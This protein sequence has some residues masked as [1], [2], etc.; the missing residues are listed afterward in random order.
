MDNRTN[1]ERTM[2]AGRLMAVIVRLGDIGRA[3]VVM[4]TMLALLC[5]AGVVVAGS[6]RVNWLRGAA[7]PLAAVLSLMAA[8]PVVKAVRIMPLG[9]RAALEF[10]RCGIDPAPA[11]GLSAMYMC[12]AAAC[13]FMVLLLL[14]GPGPMFM[15]ML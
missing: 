7:A 15:G 9:L 14:R 1:D 2:M 10:G 4:R 3:P 6:E 13:V 5:M 11:F 12:D 8:A